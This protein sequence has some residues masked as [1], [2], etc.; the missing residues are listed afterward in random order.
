MIWILLIAF[1]VQQCST[2]DFP[3]PP[4]RNPDLEKSRRCTYL[5]THGM[6]GADCNDLKLVDIPPNL[7][8]GIEVLDVTFNRIRDIYNTS[9]ENYPYL[10]I[11]YLTDNSISHIEAGAFDPIP[12]LEILDLT[13]NSLHFV[14]EALETLTSLKKLM[15]ANNPFVE[16]TFSKSLPSVQYLSLSS[17]RLKKFPDFSPLPGLVQLN[18]SD[19]NLQTIDMTQVAPMC[20]LKLLDLR[21]NTRL[22]RREYCNC[23][24]L[25][26][27]FTNLSREGFEL[28]PEIGVFCKNKTEGREIIDDPEICFTNTTALLLEKSESIRRTCEVEVM[29]YTSA[30]LKLKASAKWVIIVLTSLGIIFVCAFCLYYVRKRQ[31]FLKAASAR[32]MHTKCAS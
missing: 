8:S 32:P 27:W 11:L 10:R 13:L 7:R 30:A 25:A 18:M 20:S 21:R 14:P 31:A 29:N 19:N 17:C 24:V 5:R 2:D 23:E 12:D 3:F 9:F 16:V 15:L 4:E 22:F 1:V 26:K 6:L 28:L